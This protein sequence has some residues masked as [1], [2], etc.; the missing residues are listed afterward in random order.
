LFHCCCPVRDGREFGAVQERK[1]LETLNVATSKYL[2]YGMSE[3]YLH[4]FA[5]RGHIHLYAQICL[6]CEKSSVIVPWKLGLAKP[7]YHAKGTNPEVGKQNSPNTK[8]PFYRLDYGLHCSSQYSALLDGV[9]A[10]VFSLLKF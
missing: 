10:R 3:S 6:P 4:I 8:S 9:G 7:T 2:G 1:R 5:E